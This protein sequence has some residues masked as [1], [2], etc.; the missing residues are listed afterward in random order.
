MD[1]PLSDKRRTEKSISDPK[2][3]QR[4]KKAGSSW[5]L[6]RQVPFHT[7]LKGRQLGSQLLAKCWSSVEWASINNRPEDAGEDREQEPIGNVK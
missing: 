2:V 7:E 5:G 1:K 6:H 4:I 3:S